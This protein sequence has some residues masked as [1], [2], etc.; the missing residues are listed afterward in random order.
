LHY[1]S[2]PASYLAAFFADFLGSGSAAQPRGAG[3]HFGQ[4]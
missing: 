1:G 2:H 4:K 3:W